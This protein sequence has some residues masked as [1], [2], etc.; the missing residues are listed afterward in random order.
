M[1]LTLTSVCLAASLLAP[2]AI[3][4]AVSQAQAANY[5]CTHFNSFKCVVTSHVGVAYVD[6]TTSINGS[7]T[8]TQRTAFHGCPRRA[9]VHV[10]SDIHTLERLRVK[11]CLQD[12]TLAR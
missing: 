11:E 2:P 5:T 4:G 7:G 3:I 8:N 6:V 10:G 9:S 12:L 1:R